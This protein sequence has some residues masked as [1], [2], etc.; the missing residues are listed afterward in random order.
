MIGGCAET[1]NL[2][3][4][5]GVLDAVSAPNYACHIGALPEGSHAHASCPVRR[6]ISPVTSSAGH[7]EIR[8]SHREGD[9]YAV[10]LEYTSAGSVGSTQPLGD[11]PALAVVDREALMPLALN[12]DEYGRVLTR[13]PPRRRSGAPGALSCAR[14]CGGQRPDPRLVRFGDVGTACPWESLPGRTV[15]V[16][17]VI[18]AESLP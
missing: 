8:L 12:P 16:S 3:E 17:G 1:V 7:L 15:S 2:S 9:S 18:P 10:R 6:S 11:Q 5:C 4:S 13:G 14:E